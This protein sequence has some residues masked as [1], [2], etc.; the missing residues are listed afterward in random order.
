[1]KFAVRFAHFFALCA[2][3][4]G[5][6]AATA[7]AQETAAPKNPSEIVTTHSFVSLDP[8]PRGKEFQAAIVV[9]IATGYHMNSHKPSDSY[10]IP[11][12]VTPQLPAGFTLAEA[13]YPAGRN[14]KFPFSPDKPL[15]VYSGSVTFRLRLAADDGAALGAATI[16]VTLRFQACN[17]SACLPPVKVPVSLELQVVAAGASTHAAHPE[18]FSA[19]PSS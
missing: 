17:L 10:L 7:P 13:I 19:K 16:P 11:T 3:T 6:G 5:S 2:F 12:T 9:K 8:V 1:M 4:L 14:E 18:I 15:N